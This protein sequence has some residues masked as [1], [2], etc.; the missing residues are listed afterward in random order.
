MPLQI[1]TPISAPAGLRRSRLKLAMVLAGALGLSSTGYADTYRCRATSGQVIISS[2]PCDDAHRTTTVV[3]AQTGEEWRQRQAQGDLER[4]RQW[5]QQ[6]EQEQRRPQGVQYA[7][8][9]RPTGDA[10]DPE[11]RDRIHA[12]L[13]AVTATSGLSAVQA[14]QRRV[15][16]YHGTYGL[17]DE[18]EMR[19]TGTG[20]LTTSQ[21]QSLRQQC[22]NLSG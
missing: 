8:E 9:R 17:R 22:R 18:C 1:H 21:E 19:V 15:N 20:G 6:R 16:C 7:P 10:H 2:A 14:G 3:P 13:M 4:Q 5:L 11:G 12:C